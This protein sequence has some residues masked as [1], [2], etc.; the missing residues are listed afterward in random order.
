[1]GNKEVK[2][3]CYGDDAVM[4][5]ENEDACLRSNRQWKSITLYLFE[6]AVIVR[7]PK[8]RETKALTRS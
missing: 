8:H 3:I 1:M 6:K 5:S 2:V 4:I 7:E